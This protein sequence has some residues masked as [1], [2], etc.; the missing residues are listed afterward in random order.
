MTSAKLLRYNGYIEAHHNGGT[1]M[2]SP[3]KPL[4][5]RVVMTRE[6]AQEKT[7]SGIFLPENAKEKLA[8]F[9]VV[10]VG[11]DVKEVKAKDRVIYNGYASEVKH[12][13]VDYIIVK[14]EEILATVA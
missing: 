8:V 3:F 14:E 10:A 12:G 7:T 5:D 1:R 11:P 6:A 9:T 13:N 4:A 2:S